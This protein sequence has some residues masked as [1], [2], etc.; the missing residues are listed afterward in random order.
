MNKI[1]GYLVDKLAKPLAA[2][3]D[4]RQA[5]L[6]NASSEMWD[7]LNDKVDAWL[8]AKSNDDS[9]NIVQELAKG[10]IQLKVGDEDVLF[11]TTQA[12]DIGGHFNMLQLDGPNE[13]EVTVYLNS[14]DPHTQADDTNK[15]YIFEQYIMKQNQDKSDVQAPIVVLR[16][17]FAPFGGSI[18]LKQ[19]NGSTISYYYHL[20]RR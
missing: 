2:E 5:S 14:V 4:A 10:R 16:P 12:G 13:A 15:P 11:E 19:V 18:K 20:Y 3:I 6:A 7:E 17:V 1:K 9:L 8:D